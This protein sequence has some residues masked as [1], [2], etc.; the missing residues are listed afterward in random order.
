MTDLGQLSTIPLKKGQNDPGLEIVLSMTDCIRKIP[1]CARK[2]LCKIL[3]DE[4]EHYGIALRLRVSQT[5]VSPNVC[6]RFVTIT[7]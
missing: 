4:V 6:E 3:W 7:I 1:L 5:L 2:L